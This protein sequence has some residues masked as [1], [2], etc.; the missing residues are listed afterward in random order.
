[1]YQSA[2]EYL[3]SLLTTSVAFGSIG[4]FLL[5]FF[6]RLGETYQIFSYQRRKISIYLITKKKKLVPT[7]KTNR[8]GSQ[9]RTNPPPPLPNTPYANYAIEKSLSHTEKEALSSSKRI[10]DPC[11]EKMCYKCGD[12]KSPEIDHKNFQ[13]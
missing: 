11:V 5:T 12:S 3:I 10:L 1:M 9:S 2:F 8:T 13:G 7:N 4:V 6:F